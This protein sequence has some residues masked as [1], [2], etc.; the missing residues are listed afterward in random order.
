[1]GMEEKYPEGFLN[2]FLEMYNSERGKSH[3]S[4]R[5]HVQVALSAEGKDYLIDLLNEI[6]LIQKNDDMQ[7]VL[8]D[9]SSNNSFFKAGDIEIFKTMIKDLVSID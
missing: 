8:A 5:N 7:E 3:D 6:E 2:H 4:F 9:L 1:M